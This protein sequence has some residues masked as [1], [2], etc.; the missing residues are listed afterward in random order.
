M[1]QTY[2]RTPHTRLALTSKIIIGAVHGTSVRTSMRMLAGLI[3]RAAARPGLHLKAH[4]VRHRQGLLQGRPLAAQVEA[5]PVV[6]RGLPAALRLHRHRV[7]PAD[8]RQGLLLGLHPDRLPVA[9]ADLRQGLLLGLHLDRL[10]VAPADLRQGL[11]L[12]LH[13]DRLP[14]APADHQAKAPHRQARP[15]A[16]QAAQVARLVAALR[17]HR[18][19]VRLQVRLGL[20]PEVH[21]R[22]HPVA[23]RG[24][25][26]H[27]LPVVRQ[28]HHLKGHLLQVHQARRVGLPLVLLV[29]RLLRLHREAH[30]EVL[31][32]PRLHRQVALQVDPPLEAPLVV[33]A[34]R[35]RHHRVVH[36]PVAPAVRP[37]GVHRKVHL[38][39][40]HLDRQARHHPRDGKRILVGRMPRCRSMIP[41]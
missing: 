34:V 16:R 13:L 2:H 27:H 12:G 32:G 25:R 3:R 22:V 40:L 14:A 24:H 15:V 7:A 20:R 19:K 35:L 29:N 5:L 31:A 41:S 8:L 17:G 9:P 4:Q 38:Q 26:Q 1:G 23:P 11:L 6:R 39:L 18:L 36:L 30:L 10:P 21:R 37:P 28:D 33:Q